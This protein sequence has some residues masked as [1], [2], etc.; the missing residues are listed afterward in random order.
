MLFRSRDRSSATLNQ[1]TSQDGWAVGG[2]ATH[3]STCSDGCLG[4]NGKHFEAP[5]SSHKLGANFCLADGSVKFLSENINIFILTALGSMASG[6]G[7][8]EEL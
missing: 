5:G 1:L 3:F 4:I 8:S 6:D 2:A 7:P